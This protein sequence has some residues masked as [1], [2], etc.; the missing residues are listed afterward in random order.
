M[1][2]KI[3]FE[4]GAGMAL[5]VRG[6]MMVFKANSVTTVGAFSLIERKLPVGSRRPQ[7]HTHEALWIGVDGIEPSQMMTANDLM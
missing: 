2:A 1:D 5:T 7:P 4:P 3:F 6:S